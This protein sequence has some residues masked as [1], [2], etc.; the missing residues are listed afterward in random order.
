MTDEQALKGTIITSDIML[1]FLTN[2]SD[3]VQCILCFI[4]GTKQQHALNFSI[5]M[6]IQLPACLSWLALHSSDVYSQG[7]A[8]MCCLLSSIRKQASQRIQSCRLLSIL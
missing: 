6:A 5:D 2:A 1:D 7:P 4:S 3:T 8:R